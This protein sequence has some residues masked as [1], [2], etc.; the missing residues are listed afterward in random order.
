MQQFISKHTIEPRNEKGAK[1][2]QTKLN[3]RI[4]QY[5]DFNL[6]SVIQYALDLNIIN[7]VTF[8][9][10]KVWKYYTK[11]VALKTIGNL[12][13]VEK[14]TVNYKAAFN[15]ENNKNCRF[16][17]NIAQK[18]NKTKLKCGKAGIERPLPGFLFSHMAAFWFVYYNKM[19]IYFSYFSSSELKW[20]LFFWDTDKRSLVTFD[21][22]SII[23][24][25]FL[26]TT[27]PSFQKKW[28]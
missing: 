17:S 13:K 25:T 9:L 26:I 20:S 5:L 24:G 11:L 1:H 18:R 14:H 10:K 8:P 28:S 23:G 2:L 7:F 3:G 21:R 27:N 15:S 6:S 19:D 4:E 22:W 12:S 16:A